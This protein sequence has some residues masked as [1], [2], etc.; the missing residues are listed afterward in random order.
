MVKVIFGAASK[1]GEK[2]AG[3]RRARRSSPAAGCTGD[4]YKSVG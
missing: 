1:T 3:R 4:F 2:L